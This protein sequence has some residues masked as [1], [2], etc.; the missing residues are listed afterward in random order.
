MMAR[1]G[2]DQTYL[3]AFKNMP[4]ARKFLKQTELDG[5][6]PRMVVKGNKTT[7]LQIARGAGAVGILIDYDPITQRYG[8][9]TELS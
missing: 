9:A 8:A 5:A 3:L 4:S 7:I 6:E 1:T 2:D